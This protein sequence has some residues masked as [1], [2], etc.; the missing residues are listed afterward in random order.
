MKPIKSKQFIVLYDDGDCICLPMQWDEECEGAI[1]SLSMP[2]AIA[3]FPSRV[4][5][6]KAIKISRSFALLQ[7]AQGK[8][9][10]A[11]FTEELNHIKIIPLKP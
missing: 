10:N 7:K 1:C 4:N 3:V 11:D 5:A 9:Y 2:N 8:P 6:R